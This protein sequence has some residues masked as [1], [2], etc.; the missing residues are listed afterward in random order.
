[1]DR[2]EELCQK[3]LELDDSLSTPYSLLS[4]IYDMRMQ[5]DKAIALGERAVYIDPSPPNMYSF[6][7][8]LKNAGKHEE[9]IAWWEKAFRLD[10]IAPAY[11]LHGSGNSYFLA[12]RYADALT[13]YQRLLDRAKKGEYNPLFP[14]LFLAQTY[15]MLGQE[16]EAQEHVAEVLKL[17]PNYSIKRYAK[18]LARYYKDKADRDH[19]INSLRKA[20]LPE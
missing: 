7:L 6:A 4:R 8:N 18:T 10:P 5:K 14:H 15:V 1:M 11:S 13:Q 3:V 12:G 20:G 19:L 2:A 17:K 16:K 9:S